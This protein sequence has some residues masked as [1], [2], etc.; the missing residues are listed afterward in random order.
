MGSIPKKNLDKT[1]K[2]SYIDF[3]NLKDAPYWLVIKALNGREG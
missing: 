3:C 1:V 2:S